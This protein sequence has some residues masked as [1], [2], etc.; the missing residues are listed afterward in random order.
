MYI[1]S[2]IKTKHYDNF[3]KIQDSRPKSNRNRK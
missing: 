1:C 2:V 3:R